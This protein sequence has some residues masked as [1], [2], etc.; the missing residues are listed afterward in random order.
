ML[1]LLNVVLSAVLEYLLI[2][3]EL[4]NLEGEVYT[5]TTRPQAESKCLA[6]TF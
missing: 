4:Y 5:Y 6:V 3:S 1:F 2:I